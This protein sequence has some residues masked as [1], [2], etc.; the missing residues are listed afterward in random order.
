MIEN[1]GNFPG[2]PLD[3]CVVDGTL[4]NDAA[5]DR[6]NENKPTPKTGD[7]KMTTKPL[8]YDFALSDDLNE[9][10]KTAVTLLDEVRFKLANEG[11]GFTR[12]FTD[13]LT[14]GTKQIV[15][16]IR[17]LDQDPIV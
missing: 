9:K 17:R 10:L 12:E 8:D 5:D 6:R 1:L 13:E 14:Q 15:E 3:V 7:T 11:E 4:S 16:A 2:S